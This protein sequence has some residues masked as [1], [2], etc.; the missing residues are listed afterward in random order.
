[1][2]LC[3][4]KSELAIV[5]I[6]MELI[7]LISNYML[8]RYGQGDTLLLYLK[9]LICDGLIIVSYVVLATVTGEGLSWLAPVLVVGITSIVLITYSTYQIVGLYYYF[10]FPKEK[11]IAINK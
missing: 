9:F 8:Y 7:W 2:C 4:G 1:M 6:G 5:L 11:P 10:I 3:V